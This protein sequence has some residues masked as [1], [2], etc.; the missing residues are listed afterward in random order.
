MNEK[1]MKLRIKYIDVKRLEFFKDNINSIVGN[2]LQDLIENIK[3]VGIKE[4][5][6]VVEDKD[7]YIVVDGNHRLAIAK[8]IN[9]EKVELFNKSEQ[10]LTEVS[11]RKSSKEVDGIQWGGII[12]IWNAEKGKFIESEIV[13][14]IF[15]HKK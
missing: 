6:I 5:L 11:I 4:P 10:K 3:S 9:M 2:K 14:A 8:L 13:P 12:F 15:N 1:I 7:K